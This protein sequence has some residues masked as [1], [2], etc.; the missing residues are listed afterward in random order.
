MMSK[1][2]LIWFGK[3]I[4]AGVV[5]LIILSVFSLFY[6]NIG[7]RST[8]E[9]GATDYVWE[10]HFYST[11]YEG[12]AWGINDANGLNNSWKTEKTDEI[13]IL[14]MGSSQ[15]EA[16]NVAQNKNTAFL[17]NQMCADAEIDLYTYNIGVEGHSIYA[18]VN[19]LE[20]A[21]REFRPSKYIILET[22]EIMLDENSMK[23]VL[24]GEW[25]HSPAYDEG[26]IYY[27]QK[28]PFL[29]L[30]HKQLDNLKNIKEEDNLQEMNMVSEVEINI[31]YV[32]Q[33]SEFISYAA[34]IADRQ[35]CGLIVVYL[36]STNID[37][38][39]KFLLD[40]QSD[41]YNIFENVCNQNNIAF[42]DMIDAYKEKYA[43]EWKL[44]Y[45]FSNTEV[46]KGHLNETG[47]K[48]IAQNLF[49][50]I[51]SLEKERK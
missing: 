8:N 21:V 27:L 46:G 13:D 39:G 22:R 44:P 25:E 17:L 6:Y 37:E 40:E 45:G 11:G 1:K 35:G 30:I 15:M 14:L 33:L 43:M 50:T 34:E 26:I 38:E 42:V 28:I 47:H 36:P 19:N 32:E 31:D 9:A 20:N 51:V 48:L 3:A 12:F 4:C 10:N 23:Q 49:E 7:I 29:R 18:Q 24:G 16:R 2:I 41:Y 5:S